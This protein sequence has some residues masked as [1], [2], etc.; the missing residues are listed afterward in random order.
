MLIIFCINLQ[1]K[2]L[3]GLYNRQIIIKDEHGTELE[4][5]SVESLHSK[6][7][8][9]EPYYGRKFVKDNISSAENGILSK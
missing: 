1:I 7:V 5:C 4:D 9:I 8:F 6:T 2:D 3:F